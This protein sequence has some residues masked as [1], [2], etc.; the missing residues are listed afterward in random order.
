MVNLSMF[1][2][3]LILLLIDSRWGRSPVFHLTNIIFIVL[4]VASQFI[5]GYYIPYL[6]V[7]ALGSTFSPLGIRLSYTLGN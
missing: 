5:T 7:I 3:G 6:V 1:S 4:R 2:L